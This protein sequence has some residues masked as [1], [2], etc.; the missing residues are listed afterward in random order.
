MKEKEILSNLGLVYKATKSMNF[1][2]RNDDEEWDEIFNAGVIGLIKAV[3]TYNDKISK[4]GTYYYQC[5]ANEI[6]NVYILRTAQK[7]NKKT[8]S[9]DTCIST[10]DIAFEDT[11]ASDQNIEEE[12][13]KQEEIRIMLETLERYKNKKHRDIVK[14]NFGIG[15]KRLKVREIAEKYHMSNQ[16][17]SQA[18]VKVLKWLRNELGDIENE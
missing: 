14:E 9:L 15:C 5:I 7:R 16:N 11:L 4:K 18:K 12:Y 8:Y 2:Q 6:R 13:I 1:Q 3:N 17:V 10:T